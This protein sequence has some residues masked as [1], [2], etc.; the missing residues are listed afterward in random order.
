MLSKHTLTIKQIRTK[1]LFCHLN[2]SSKKETSG[3]FYTDE[4]CQTI[5]NEKQG[6]RTSV[7]WRWP[8]CCKIK[9][10]QAM[11]LVKPIARVQSVRRKMVLDNWDSGINRDFGGHIGIRYFK[12]FNSCT[13]YSLFNGHFFCL[14][15]SETEQ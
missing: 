11:R 5:E 10:C 4:W 6:C 9:F 3:K 13:V 14:N 8:K 7:A 12:N 1:L 15:F 2:N